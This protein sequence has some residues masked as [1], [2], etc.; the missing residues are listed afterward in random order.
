MAMSAAAQRTDRPAA[1]NVAALT[2]TVFVAFL[3]AP[4][5]LGQVAEHIGIRWTYG[6]GLPLVLVGLWMVQALGPEP[7]TQLKP[8]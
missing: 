5:L 7:R 2:Q 1:E 3:L 4:P 8:A 6:I